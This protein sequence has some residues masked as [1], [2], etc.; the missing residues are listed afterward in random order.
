MFAKTT[1]CLSGR[2]EYYYVSPEKCFRNSHQHKQIVWIRPGSVVLVAVRRMTCTASETV[3]SLV[4]VSG[5]P[6]LSCGSSEVEQY[7]VTAVSG[8]QRASERELAG[9]GYDRCNRSPQEYKIFYSVLLPLSWIY[10]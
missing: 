9:V 4:L 3:T 7:S 6:T 8:W 10:Y 1:R 2:M 5:W